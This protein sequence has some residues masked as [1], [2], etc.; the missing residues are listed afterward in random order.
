MG[1]GLFPPGAIRPEVSLRVT[2][3]KGLRQ[4][5]IY[6]TDRD[7]VVAID[8]YLALRV[9]CRWR[10]SD[11]SHTGR[12]TMATRLLANGVELATVQLMLGH[13]ELDHIG[14]YLEVDRRKLRQ[15]STDVL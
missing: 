5:C 6:P 10:M 14:P 11:S 12:R 7:L 13:G 8:V 9:A 2:I 1:D 15:A 4:R 3:T